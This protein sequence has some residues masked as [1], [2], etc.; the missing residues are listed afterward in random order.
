M[1]G[2]VKIVTPGHVYVLDLLDGNSSLESKTLTFVRRSFPCL[3]REDVHPGTTNQD[4]LRCLIDRVQVLDSERHW[5]GNSEIL[6]HLRMALVLHEAR[7]LVRKV[8]SGR[9]VPEQIA[10]CP[11]D[12]HWIIEKAHITKE[13]A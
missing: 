7:T 3:P 1:G 12:G 2:G 8:E 10:T 13:E 11:A 9:I 6:Y 4:V 5:D